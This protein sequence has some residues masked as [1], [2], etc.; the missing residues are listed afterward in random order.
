MSLNQWF[1]VVGLLLL[2]IGGMFL[3]VGFGVSPKRDLSVFFNSADL[4]V[5][6]KTGLVL[7]CMGLFLLIVSRLLPSK[8]KKKEN[9][10]TNR[11]KGPRQ[12]GRRAS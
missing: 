11:S 6:W 2:I 8:L 9:H 3:P 12:K 10:L 5:F 7:L 1:K 4:G